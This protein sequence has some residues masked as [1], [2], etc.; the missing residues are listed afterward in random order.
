MIPETTLPQTP[1]NLPPNSPV[2]PAEVPS[3]AAPSGGAPQLTQQ[4]SVLYFYELRYD[5]R[6]HIM[7]NNFLYFTT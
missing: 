6:D 1:A 5:S 2:L 3:V 7:K 4:V